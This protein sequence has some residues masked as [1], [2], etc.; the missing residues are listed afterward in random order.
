MNR[1]L[2]LCAN[3]FENVLICIGEKLFLEI[4][5]SLK[6]KY[7]ETHLFQKISAHRYLHK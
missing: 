2:N 6:I 7:I 1:E 3:Q 5:K 4:I